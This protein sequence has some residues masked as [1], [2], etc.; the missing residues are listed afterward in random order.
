M[1][2]RAENADN[3]L[4]GESHPDR[5]VNPTGEFQPEVGEK[6]TAGRVRA[7]QHGFPEAIPQSAPRTAWHSDDNCRPQQY[8]ESLSST[9]VSGRKIKSGDESARMPFVSE[10]GVDC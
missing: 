8:T 9:V 4:D 7:P 3:L 5:V 1:E 6:A 10:Q 2:D